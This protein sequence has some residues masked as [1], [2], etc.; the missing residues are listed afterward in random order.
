M[1]LFLI[2][3]TVWFAGLA[4]PVSAV[5]TYD[6]IFRSGTL[7]AVAK[8]T[9]L[10]YERK[11]FVAADPEFSQR[12]TGEVRLIF[13]ADDMA[14]LQFFQGKKHR[15]IGSFPATVGNPVIMYFVESVVRE[16]A[17]NAGGSPFYIRNRVKES[18]IQFAEIVGT[19]AGF[20]GTQVPVQQITL[21]PFLN[22]KNREKMK[23]YADLALTITMSDDVPGWYLSLDARVDG[24]VGGAPIYESSLTLRAGEA[25]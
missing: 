17:Q 13:E 22:D 11:L 9:E 1:R 24:T 20:G 8:D 5:E 16:V 14:R 6:L 2:C 10:R 15:N 23:G 19:E 7:D 21:R 18:L 12:N 3:L 4:S 25:Q